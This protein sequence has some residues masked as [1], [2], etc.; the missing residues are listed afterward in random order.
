M[1]LV[2]FFIIDENRWSEFNI[3]WHLKPYKY[4]VILHLFFG[5]NIN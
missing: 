2:G 3:K 5:K 4:F 1:S